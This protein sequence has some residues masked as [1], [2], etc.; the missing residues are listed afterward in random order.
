MKKNRP[1]SIFKKFFK[2]FFIFLILLIGFAFAAPYLF[3]GKIIELAKKEINKNIN[4]KADFKDVDISFFKSFPKVSVS[5]QDFRIIG[6]NEFADDTLIA[7]KEINTSLDIMTVIKGAD[8]KLYSITIDEPR[9]HA[10]VLK[11]GRANWDIAKETEPATTANTEEKPYSLN[12]QHYAI[13]NGYIHYD[14][15]SSNMSSEII[16]LNHEGNGDFTADLFTLV[17]K[18]SADAVSF[19]YGGIPYLSKT[20]TIMDADIEVDNKTGK[21]SFKKGAVKLNELILATDG[22]FQLVND[23]TYN[24]DIQF[25]AASTDFKNILSLVPAV[26]KADFDK[27]KTSGKAVFNGFVKGTYSAKQMPAYNL[28]LAV[29]N[30]FFQYPDLPLPV[31]NINL[32]MNVNN[33]DGITDHTIVNIPQAHIE[34]DNE[35]FDFRLFMKTPMS[36][37]FID[38]AIKGKLNLSKVSQFVKLEPGTKLKGVMNADVAINGNMSAIEQQRYDE[39]RATGNILLKDFLYASTDYPDGVSL[40]Y[41]AMAFNP[42]NVTLSDVQGQYMKTHFS[43]NGTINNLL[44]YVLKDQSLDGV[45]NVKADHINLDE[46]MGVSTDTTTASAE[47]SKPF[48]VPSNIQFVVNTTVDKVHYDKI[49]LH[50]LSGSLEMADETVQLNN[51][52]ANALDGTMVINGKYSTKD[53]KLK[54]AISLTY[55]VKGLDVQKTFYAFNT[56]Q[57][58][59]PIGKFIAGK[60]SSQLSFTGLLGDNMMPDLNSLTGQGNLLLIE[61]FL[62]KFGPVDKLAQTL[63]IKELETISLKDVKNYIQF[64]NGKVLVKPFTIKA[65]EIGIEIGG[66][67]GLDQSLDYIINLKLPRSVMGGKGNQF[68]NSLVTQ[69]ND[70]GV[71][72]KIAEVINLHVLL[73]G[74]ISNPVFKTDLKQSASSLA[75]DLK[76]QV[77]DFAKQKIDSTKTAVTTAVKDTIASVKKQAAD[78]AK[79]ELR[80]RL[81]GEKD[82]TGSTSKDSK[83]KIEETGKGLIEGFNPFKKKKKAVDTTK[84][85]G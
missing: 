71:P 10:I 36:D 74:T 47:E 54:P 35:P 40:N 75:A 68:V 13:N 58:L 30:G 49:D 46:W 60:L 51:V 67:H 45:L 69:V 82:T 5:L 39:F 7:A 18:T 65:K 61:G 83:T 9:I 56:L 21:Y 84:T 6:H 70:K 25:N 37:L 52:K 11:D 55:D 19:V 38:A 59:M 15:A 66:M 12:L 32:T 85:S 53:N 20:K 2:I 43:G 72:V 78:V 33:P 81:T 16:N 24:M 62:K 57:K 26:Y 31:K 17:T 73:G 64:T 4:A 22:F 27:V 77:T 3:K 80:K 29:E 79:E 42:K 8:Y 41:L 28:N 48:L 63:S 76:Q 14:D 1:V 50:N 34:L 44:G 23:S